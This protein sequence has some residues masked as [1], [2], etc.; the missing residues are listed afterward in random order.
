MVA[1]VAGLFLAATEHPTEQKEPQ[2]P[3]R[4]HSCV[5]SRFC[6]RLLPCSPAWP[7]CHRLK[8]RFPS[9]SAFSPFAHTAITDISHMA[10]RPWDITDPATFT[11]AS[12]WVWALGLVGVMAMVGEAT[13]LTAMVA[14]GFTAESAELPTEDPQAAGTKLAAAARHSMGTAATRMPAEHVPLRTT[15]HRATQHRALLPHGAAANLTEALHNRTAAARR[16]V[17]VLP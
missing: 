13:A 7:S 1:D 9:T 5:D 12:S 8:R 3:E 17:E 10:A 4:S 2:K 15:G 11:T 6:F 14:E 16:T